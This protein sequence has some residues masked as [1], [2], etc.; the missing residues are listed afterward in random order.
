VQKD[1]DPERYFF[2]RLNRV[3]KRSDFLDVY[4]RGKCYRRRA[5]HVFVLPRED[6]ALPTRV[7]MTATRKVGGA[8]VR[9]RLKRLGRESFRLALPS[10]KT[11]YTIIINFLQSAAKVKFEAIDDQLWSVWRDAGLVRD[12]AQRKDAQ[13]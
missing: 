3:Q 12:D 1:S 10:L 5:V 11:G 8:V 6:S 4:E 9:N 2:R 7:G 13:S